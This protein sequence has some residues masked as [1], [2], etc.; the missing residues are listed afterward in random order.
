L[1]EGLLVGTDRTVLLG[2]TIAPGGGVRG[3]IDVSF[4]VA[5]RTPPDAISAFI[6]FLIVANLAPDG[7]IISSC[8]CW[9]LPASLETS[10][11]LELLVFGKSAIG[12]A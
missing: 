2:E 3:D 1:T 9:E 7:E 10:S 4:A 6:S 5:P 12:S 8:F 11:G